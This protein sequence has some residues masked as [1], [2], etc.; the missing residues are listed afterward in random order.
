MCSDE[1]GNQYIVEMQVA[2]K[3]VT[4]KDLPEIIGQDPIIQRAYEELDKFGWSEEE[5]SAYDAVIKREMDNKAI[6]DKQYNK[7]KLKVKLK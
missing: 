5:L 4:D 7:V 2:E 3:D 6:L 1:V